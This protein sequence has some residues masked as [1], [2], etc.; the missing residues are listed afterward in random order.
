MARRLTTAAI[1]FAVAA[2]LAACGTSTQGGGG[3]EPTA[4]AS[5]AAQG[6]HLPTPPSDNDGPGDQSRAAPAAAARDV[7]TAFTR[8]WARP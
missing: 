2:A 6:T 3:G 5:P 4:Y 1:L 8:A 7:A